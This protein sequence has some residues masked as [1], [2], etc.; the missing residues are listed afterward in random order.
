MYS[1]M[2]ES[3]DYSDNWIKF[4]KFLVKVCNEDGIF[5]FGWFCFFDVL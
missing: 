3:L 1:G 2:E 5:F 4:L